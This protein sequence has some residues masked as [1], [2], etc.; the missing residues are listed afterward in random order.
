VTT[1]SDYYVY[2]LVSSGLV[3]YV[4]K[5]CGYRMLS[6]GWE[7]SDSAAAQAIRALDAVG[8]T[9]QAVKLADGLDEAEA[10]RRERRFLGLVDPRPLVNKIGNPWLAYLLSQKLKH[11]AACGTLFRMVRRH[12]RRNLE[13][14]VA[15]ALQ[16]AAFRRAARHGAVALE[17]VV[18]RNVPL[19]IGGWCAESGRRAS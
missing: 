14:E 6:H 11:C 16:T 17:P 9:W 18:T 19:F 5:G 10:F 3:F 1:A 7:S 4:G 2:A 12:A 13:S 8:E 15:R